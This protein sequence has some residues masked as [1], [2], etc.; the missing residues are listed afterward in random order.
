M[1]STD[2]LLNKINQT[3]DGQPMTLADLQPFS[4]GELRKMFEEQLS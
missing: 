1:Y 4:F 2:L 3:R